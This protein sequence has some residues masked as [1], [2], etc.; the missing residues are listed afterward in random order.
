MI[1]Y[2]QQAHHSPR[3]YLYEGDYLSLTDL[4]A[5]PECVVSKPTLGQRL[6]C[7]IRYLG[8]THWP[9]VITCLTTPAIMGRPEGR[10]Y[11]I[12]EIKRR[13]EFDE[14]FIDLM[15]IMPIGSMRHKA[16]RLQSKP[17]SRLASSSCET[18][19]Q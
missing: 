2:K 9:D 12:A 11:T 14:D 8:T 13:E 15:H 1:E 10:K 5:C 6:S 7:G 18:L 16:L 3:Y 17:P 19:H 4:H